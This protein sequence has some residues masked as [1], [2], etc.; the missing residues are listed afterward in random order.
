M[1]FHG[2]FVCSSVRVVFDV[3]FL[4]DRQPSAG[5]NAE[6]NSLLFGGSAD[7][8]LNRL[9]FN[10]LSCFLGCI[11]IAFFAIKRFPYLQTE[12]IFADNGFVLKIAGFSGSMGVSFPVPHQTAFFPEQTASRFAV[13]QL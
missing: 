11:P 2:N 7:N 8:P 3:P 1:F 12:F 5:K 13:C 9:L 6:K 4:V 10:I